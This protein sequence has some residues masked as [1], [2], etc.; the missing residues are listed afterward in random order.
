FQLFSPDFGSPNL[1][2]ERSFGYDAG[3]DQLLFNGNVRVSV[4]AFKNRFNDL[5]DF[6]FTDT[7][8]FTTGQYFNVARAE[9]SGVEVEASTVL[10]PGYLG[11]K[12]AYT[13]LRAIDLSTG[14]TLI[15]RP[16]HAARLVA[17]FTPTPQWLFEPRVVFVSRRFSGTDETQPLGSYARADIYVA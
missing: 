16:R 8:N 15:R 2:P 3:I 9:T 5:I 1:R 12:A 17:S 11:L 7:I 4:T 6:R 14:L 13:T 10:V